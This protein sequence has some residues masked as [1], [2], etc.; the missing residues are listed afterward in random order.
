[1]VSD[2]YSED[3]RRHGIDDDLYRFD[4]GNFGDTPTPA[5]S[6]EDFF[7][8]PTTSAYGHDPSSA[9]DITQG[10][11]GLFNCTPFHSALPGKEVTY[12]AVHG[13]NSLPPMLGNSEADTH[14]NQTVLE[15]KMND[16]HFRNPMELDR[17]YVNYATTSSSANSFK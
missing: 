14:S 17:S 11:E 16:M 10:T 5:A 1:L 15:E 2:L 12:V 13:L 8:T 9:I 7:T 3:R 6:W 4:V